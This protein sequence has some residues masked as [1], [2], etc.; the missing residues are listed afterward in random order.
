MAFIIDS[1]SMIRTVV[2]SSQENALKKMSAHKS[3]F[4]ALDNLNAVDEKA[5][6]I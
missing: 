6:A 3:F 5:S 1:K 2:T 4:N